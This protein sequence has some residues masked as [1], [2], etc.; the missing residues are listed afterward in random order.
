MAT[1]WTGGLSDNTPLPAATLNRIGAAWETWTP[2][3]W[4]GANIAQSITY[5]EYTQIQKLVICR[6][7]VFATGA[8]VATNAIE[9]RNFP[10]SS[11][12]NFCGGSF[13]YL[14]SGVQFYAGTVI[15]QSTTSARFYFNG[16]G[17]FFGAAVTI[18]ANDYIDATFI[19]EAA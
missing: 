8:G 12:A 13:M 1:Q 11:S 2:Q 5:A 18:A 4:Q 10:I 9:I 7:I 3:L 14:D 19:Y 6:A 16:A 15:G 17:N